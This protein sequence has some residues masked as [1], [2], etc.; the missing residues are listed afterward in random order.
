MATLLARL[1]IDRAVTPEP[2]VITEE[3]VSRLDGVLD[4]AQAERKL[5]EDEAEALRAVLMV[6]PSSRRETASA[7]R[8]TAATRVRLRNG[9]GFRS[10][11]EPALLDRLA[12][13]L[14]QESPPPRP[15]APTRVLRAGAS[16]ANP[17]PPLI[18][19]LHVGSLRST[20]EEVEAEATGQAWLVS[21]S[22]LVAFMGEFGTGKSTV[23]EAMEQSAAAHADDVTLENFDALDIASLLAAD[24]SARNGAHVLLIDNFDAPAALTSESQLHPPDLRTLRPLLERGYRIAIAT[25]RVAEGPPDELLRQLNHVRSLGPMHV[26]RAHLLRMQPWSWASMREWIGGLDEIDPS[27]RRS[28]LQSARTCA[29][30]NLPC[31]PMIV[32]M[33]F[34]LSGPEREGIRSTNLVQLYD[35]YTEVAIGRNYDV[36]RSHIPGLVH[37]DIL[38]DLAEDIFFGRGDYEQPGSRLSV[39]EVR[40]RERVVERVLQHGTLMSENPQDDYDWIND[41]TNS[42]HFLTNVGERG[43]NRRRFSFQHDSFYDFF[44]A[45]S[46][47]RSIRRHEPPGLELNQTPMSMSFESLVVPFIK[48]LLEPEDTETLRSLVSRPR[49]GWMDRL[50]FFH[51]LEDEPGFRSALMDAPRS[52]LDDLDAVANDPERFFLRKLALYQLVVAER[53]DPEAYMALVTRAEAEDPRAIEIERRLQ[54]SRTK[55]PAELLLDRLRNPDLLPVAPITLYRLGQ[56]GNAGALEAIAEFAQVHPHLR[57]HCDDAAAALRDRVRNRR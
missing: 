26:R 57:R 37:G 43:P 23:L 28:L 53:A 29:D 52:Y 6:D 41:F 45:Q 48:G 51:L 39:S 9:E 42:T 1:G 36:G 20:G 12:Y 50:L 56:M 13:A 25:Q 7:R 15:T 3:L 33:L 5:D 11:R 55:A 32:S 31:I 44:V 30:H 14:G 8:Q 38:R 2:I 18:A 47:L 21:E 54:S 24:E 17:L 46:L 27:M 10:H 19:T 4:R 22:N 40:L 49:L 34:D 35:E 16:R